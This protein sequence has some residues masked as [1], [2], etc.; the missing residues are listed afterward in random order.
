M[1]SRLPGRRTLP[2]ALLCSL[3]VA[4]GA[5]GCQT[6]LVPSR[7]VD[8]S[9]LSCSS[10][11]AGSYALAQA[12]CRLVRASGGQACDAS[13]KVAGVLRMLTGK[14]LHAHRKAAAVTP[15]LCRSGAKWRAV[16]H[17]RTLAGSSASG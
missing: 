11:S 4:S 17:R 8:G 7:Q 12:L 6:Q 9:S 13:V 14:Q 10:G 2:G 1:V 16:A 3:A 15:P 5:R